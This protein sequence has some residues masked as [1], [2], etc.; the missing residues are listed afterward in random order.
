MNLNLYLNLSLRVGS[1]SPR[2]AA[3]NLKP[4]AQCWLTQAGRQAV[5][6]GKAA[7]SELWARVSIM[8]PIMQSAAVKASPAN[9]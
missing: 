1:D 6:P 5:S 2:R 3:A 4:E 8:K 7:L 9:H